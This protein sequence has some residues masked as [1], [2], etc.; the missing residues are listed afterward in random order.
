MFHA[1]VPLPNEVFQLGLNADNLLVYLY[2]QC[3]K[4][5]R[6]GQCCP[7]GEDEQETRAE[8][9]TFVDGQGVPS[10]GYHGSQEE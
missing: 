8:A 2:L 6:S 1:V 7:R 3:Q 10:G 4:G 5:V 9:R